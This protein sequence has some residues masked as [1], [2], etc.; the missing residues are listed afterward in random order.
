MLKK[1]RLLDRTRYHRQLFNNIFELCFFSR[2]KTNTTGTL[3]LM[4]KGWQF[5]LGIVASLLISAKDS[6]YIKNHF[7]SYFFDLSQVFPHSQ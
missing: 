2:H 4:S 5:A 1:N 6:N 7:P 3:T